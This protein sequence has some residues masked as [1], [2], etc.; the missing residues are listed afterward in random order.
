M[1]LKVTPNCNT[2]RISAVFLISGPAVLGTNSLRPVTLRPR[3][4]VG[5]ALYDTA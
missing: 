2:A 1:T 5:F 3:L 4:S